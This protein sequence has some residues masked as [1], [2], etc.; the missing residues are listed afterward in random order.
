MANESQNARLCIYADYKM[1]SIGCQYNLSENHKTAVTVQPFCYIAALFHGN[2]KTAYKNP[3][4]NIQ[5]FSQFFHRI[6]PE[7]NSDRI[8]SSPSSGVGR[9]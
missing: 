6:L 3:Y 1:I 4:G 5:K 2:I 9:I 8:S 7:E